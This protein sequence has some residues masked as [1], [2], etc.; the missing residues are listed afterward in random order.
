HG[1]PRGYLMRAKQ[2]RGFQTGAH[3][4][5]VVPNGRKAGVH[6]GRVAVRASGC[7]NIQTPGGVVQGISHRHC[8]LTQRADGYGYCVQPK[9]AAT[10]AEEAR[11]KAA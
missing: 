11:T 3:V 10:K 7:F 2:V 5:A 9:I 1:F 6:V 8:T 4:R